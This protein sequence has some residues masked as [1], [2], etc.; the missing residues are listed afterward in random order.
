[1]V[2]SRIRQIHVADMSMS[3]TALCLR[4]PASSIVIFFIVQVPFA[5]TL[6]AGSSV[7]QVQGNL[8]TIRA[9]GRIRITG[10]THRPRIRTKQVNQSFHL[11]RRKRGPKHAALQQDD[12]PGTPDTATD[13]FDEPRRSPLR[14]RFLTIN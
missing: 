10:E 4:L 9:D 6:L 1:M 7:D 2:V 12:A 8:T 13:H 14:T 5:A 3:R 11:G